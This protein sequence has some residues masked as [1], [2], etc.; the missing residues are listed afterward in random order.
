MRRGIQG[1]YHQTFTRTVIH[2]CG[3]AVVCTLTSCLHLCG[4]RCP[5]SNEGRRTNLSRIILL[6][7]SLIRLRRLKACSA[8]RHTVSEFKSQ[9]EV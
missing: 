4:V 1:L 2:H 3:A 5:N 7:G 8:A 9:A 6:E